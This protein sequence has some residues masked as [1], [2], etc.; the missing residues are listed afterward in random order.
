MRFI[1]RFINGVSNKALVWNYAVL[2]TH[3]FSSLPNTGAFTLTP[4]LLRDV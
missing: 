3:V 1:K 4:L 2:C